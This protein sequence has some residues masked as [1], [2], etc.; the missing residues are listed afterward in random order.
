ML[1]LLAMPLLSLE[2]RLTL[3]ILALQ[4][5]LGWFAEPEAFFAW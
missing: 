2:E 4:L 5:V 1:Y 3:R